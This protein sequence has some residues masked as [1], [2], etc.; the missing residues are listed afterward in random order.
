[1]VQFRSNV[2][3]AAL[4]D[5]EVPTDWIESESGV[6]LR[7]HPSIC[8]AALAQSSPSIPDDR[9]TAALAVVVGGLSA[10]LVAPTVDGLQQLRAVV[11]NR[12][13]IP[14]HIRDAMQSG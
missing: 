13:D 2:I 12:Q 1:M 5:R 9:L 4:R 8:L 11:R 6:L 3:T 7:E 10:G 14:S